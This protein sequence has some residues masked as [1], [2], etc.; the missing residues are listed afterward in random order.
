MPRATIRSPSI[1]T[2]SLTPEEEARVENEATALLN[3]T[4][5]IE[6]EFFA[7][8]GEV[9][10]KHWKLVKNRDS[11]CIYKERHL[12]VDEQDE[13]L[14]VE[15]SG[16]SEGQSAAIDSDDIIAS[17]KRAH[18][19]MIVSTGH[20]EG[21]LDDAV[22]GFAAGD[23]L[24]WRLRTIYMKDM[25]TDGKIVKTMHLPTEEEPLNYFCIKWFVTEFPA[26]V[27][28]F[29]NPRDF[30]VAEA[31]GIKVDEQGKRFGYY[32]IHDYE[33]STI[34]RLDEYGV[35]RC[36]MSM[37]FIVREVVPGMVHVFS[38]G[39]VDPRGDFKP[40]IAAAI[41]ARAMSAL[42]KTVE[43]SYSKKMVWLMG[44]QER[45]RQEKQRRDRSLSPD[46]IHADTCAACAKS[47]GFL[48]AKLEACR[49]CRANYCSRCTVE[50]SLVIDMSGPDVTKR[51]FTFCAGCV[52][53]AKQLAPH[54][55]AVEAVRQAQSCG[56]S[57]VVFPRASDASSVELYT[58][59][60][61]HSSNSNSDR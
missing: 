15:S 8:D 41:S 55:V 24:S 61:S 40:S 21:S 19:P 29:V 31:A 23:I 25:F 38:R 30:L 3:Q 33:H 57:T 5:Q 22:F 13:S 59:S 37:C 34:G 49:L 17:K 44:Q 10:E 28:A 6:R 45:E 11:F 54:E 20:V 4:L 16:G 35:C 32:I 46:L 50:R 60:S 43:A 26:V 47:P 51:T 1:P 39:F 36:S 2:L 27:N 56:D 12:E 52:L 14:Y 18:V 48:K 42:T 7:N 9:D 53:K 58:L